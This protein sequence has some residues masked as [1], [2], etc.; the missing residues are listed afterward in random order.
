MEK[1]EEEGGCTPENGEDNDGGGGDGR[2][3]YES[4]L[5]PH[6]RT[7]SPK[8]ESFAIKKWRCCDVLLA[9]V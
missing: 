1:E 2:S 7:P 5:R 3:Y 9:W 4:Q 6:P 8:W